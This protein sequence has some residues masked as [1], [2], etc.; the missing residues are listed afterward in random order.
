ML[1]EFS[2]PGSS[3]GGKRAKAILGWDPSSDEWSSGEKAGKWK[4]GKERGKHWLTVVD[5]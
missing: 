5:K 1:K 3:S 2:R 4:W